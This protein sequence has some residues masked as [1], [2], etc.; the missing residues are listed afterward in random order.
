MK[1][2]LNHH[3]ETA[4]RGAARQGVI[5]SYA[6]ARRKA[7]ADILDGFSGLVEARAYMDELHDGAICYTVTGMPYNADTLREIAES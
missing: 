7:E 4:K 1:T 2:S 3:I 6:E 5:I